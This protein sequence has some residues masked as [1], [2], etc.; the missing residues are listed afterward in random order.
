MKRYWLL[1][2]LFLFPAFL[3]AQDSLVSYWVEFDNKANSPYSKFN[4]SE[5]LSQKAI[6]RRNIQDIPFNEKDF[7]VNP[8]Y[9]HKIDRITAGVVVVSKWLNG[10]VARISNSSMKEAVDTLAFTDT[11]FRVKGQTLKNH[12]SS[13]VQKAKDDLTYG[14]GLHQLSMLGGQFL[15]QM[16]YKGQ[17]VG[18]AVLDAGFKG[19]KD[20]R[21]FKSLRE[22]GQLRFQENL[23]DPFKPVTSSGIHGTSVLSV[24]GGILHDTFSGVAPAANFHLFKSENT[25]SEFLVEEIAWVSAAETADSAGAKII[26]SSLGY[27]D[28]EDSTTNHSYKDLDGEST[29]IT[30]GAG[31]AADKGMLVVSSA[32]NEG[33]SDWQYITAPADGK[34]VLTVG[35]VD[36][37]G[38]RVAFSSLGP[39]AD[40]RVKPD[41]MAMGAETRLINANN[42]SVAKSFGTSFSAPLIS[43]MAACLWQAFPKATNNAVREA[44][45]ESSDQAD[46]PDSLRG[47]GI[48]D[49]YQAYVDLQAENKGT[50][51]GSHLVRVY[52]NPFEKELTVAF[53]SPKPQP[54]KLQVKSLLG[55]AVYKR[56]V[57][58]KKGLNKIEV[59]NFQP[60]QQKVYILNLA[61]EQTRISQK[62]VH[63]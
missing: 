47:Y 5:Y 3:K 58:L 8:G 46:N 24:M 27:Q 16:G 29:L 45:V 18:I 35:A 43:G 39:T 42:G 20:L 4:P 2:L 51:K 12:F 30:R 55:K 17:G 53:Y 52:P 41:V 44:I 40:G 50:R 23:V 59:I 31:V 19:V 56:E 37:V 22:T 1:L 21:A 25:E 54:M 60:G 28:F 13:T 14:S 32:G 10:V 61:L 7:P 62:L 49:F 63:Y 34:E 33:R 15:H 26:N 48:P 9:K 36:S 11:L 6:N 57:S 38:S